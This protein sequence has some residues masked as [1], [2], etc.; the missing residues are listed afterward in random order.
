MTEVRGGIRKSTYLCDVINGRSITWWCVTEEKV[1][2]NICWEFFLCSTRKRSK[3]DDVRDDLT[4]LWRSSPQIL[5]PELRKKW[6]N[7]KPKFKILW[8]RPI[9]RKA[10]SGRAAWCGACRSGDPQFNSRQWV[11]LFLEIF[12]FFFFWNGL[13]SS[14]EMRNTSLSSGDL[15]YTS[16]SCVDHQMKQVLSEEKWLFVNTNDCKKTLF[17]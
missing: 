16:L 15:G 14:L 8:L 11:K 2:L 13:T 3:R 5:E 4:R 17:V 1:L 12:L 10:K 7:L 6:Q 9:L